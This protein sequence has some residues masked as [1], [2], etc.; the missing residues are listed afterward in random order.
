MSFLDIVLL[1][2]HGSSSHFGPPS[3]PHHITQRVADTTEFLGNAGANLSYISNSCARMHFAREIHRLLP[4][5]LQGF[6]W[7]LS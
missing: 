4:F 6:Q 3:Q 5:I 7:K 2:I 1:Y